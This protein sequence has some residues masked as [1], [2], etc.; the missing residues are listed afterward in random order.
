[1]PDHYED[2]T[3]RWWHLSGPPPELQ[4]ALAAGWL[5]PGGVVLDAG[6]GAGSEAGFLH[7]AGWQVAGVDLSAAAL[8]LA[9]ASHPGPGYLRADL[10]R[11]P[12]A[13]AVFDA[14]VDRGCFHYL[15]AADRAGYAAELR[16]VL[17]PGGRLL[18]RASLTA[19]GVR[20]DIDEQAIRSAF[21]GWR[22]G[23]LER[24]KIPS[25]TRLLDVLLALLIS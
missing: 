10:R 20:N 23:H 17:R 16:R 8:A 1:M 25:D 13:R 15:A 19:E 12:F 4:R 5:P 2:G 6:C 21:A 7:Q 18:L 3:Y 14:A 22:I 11:L 9:A 24:T